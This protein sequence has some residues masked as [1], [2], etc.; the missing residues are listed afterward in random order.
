LS[1]IAVTGWGDAGDPASFEVLDK[2]GAVH[3]WSASTPPTVAILTPSAVL[4]DTTRPVITWSYSDPEGDA[5]AE[6]SVGIF[7]PAV[8]QLADFNPSK[9]RAQALFFVD[10][11]TPGPLNAAGF[12]Q[13]NDSLL[14]NQ[15]YSANVAGRRGVMPD[16]DLANNSTYRIYVA[17]K[18]S[19]NLWSNWAVLELTTDYILPDTPT[20]TATSDPTNAAV[21]LVAGNLPINTGLIIEYLED[22]AWVPVRATNPYVLPP[23]TTYTCKDYEAPLAT[24]R[25]YRARNIANPNQDVHLSSEPSPEVSASPLAYNAFSETWWI[26]VPMNPSLNMSV[27]KAV[28]FD[29]QKRTKSAVVEPAGERY[30]VVLSDG[31]KGYEGSLNIYALTGADFRGIE[32]ILD[33]DARCLVQSPDGLHNRYVKF[34]QPTFRQKREIVTDGA[35]QNVAHGHDISLHWVEVRRP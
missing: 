26:K 7:T 32:K 11:L 4:T 9:H 21:T 30:A 31:A 13:P 22:G 1:D 17:A 35:A 3:K 2:L 29:F 6:F 10:R 19:S 24:L 16:V 28:G 33:S 5:Q 34:D 20:L 25:T 18:D 23:L 8:Y 27:N 12:V 14:P 15:P